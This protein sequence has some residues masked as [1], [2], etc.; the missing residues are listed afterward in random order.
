M[1]PPKKS[2]AVNSLIRRIFA[3]SAMKIKAKPPA[4]YSTL[5]P[6]TSSDSPSA[7]SNGARFVSAR[8]ETNQT[9]EIGASRKKSHSW[10]QEDLISSKLNL[11]VVRRQNKRIKASLTS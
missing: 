6:E 4:L 3:Y 8:Q 11:L 7:K 2:V 5:K 9:K 1:S 10:L